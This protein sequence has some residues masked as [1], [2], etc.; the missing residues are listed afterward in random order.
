MAS[1]VDSRFDE[2][3]LRTTFDHGG[4]FSLATVPDSE[5]LSPEDLCLIVQRAQQL[6]AGSGVE[7]DR[8]QEALR[9]VTPPLD[10]EE[11][12]E[13][14]RRLEAEARQ[15]LEA[16]G[17]PPCYPPDVDVHSSQELPDSCRAIVKYWLS[18]SGGEDVPLCYQLRDWRK[19]RAYQRRKRVR[20]YK[21]SARGV[22][23]LRQKCGLDYNVRLAIDLEQQSP[24]DRW[25]EYQ[26]Y[27]LEHLEQLEKERD[28]FI[29][30]LAEFRS[31][32]NNMHDFP[33]NGCAEMDIERH[34]VLLDWIEKER[35][36]MSPRIAAT[37]L[38]SSTS[39]VG[40]KSPST[41]AHA[42][43][44]TTPKDSNVIPQKPAF[45]R[46]LR[47][48]N[49]EERNINEHSKDDSLLHHQLRPQRVTKR[50]HRARVPA[51]AG[52]LETITRY[53]RKSKLAERW[54]P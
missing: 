18:F 36:S 24:L 2:L 14:S 7:A 8:L 4:S 54:S 35:R 41:Q 10:E 53:G 46:H 23:R 39:T 12:R 32:N 13:I 5:G 28:Q 33:L 45:Q 52:P 42:T 17:C 27:H 40:Q 34:R 20:R 37:A 38:S 16:E 6:Q 30:E 43:T 9:D 22:Y 51:S 15:K 49:V 3:A 19:F 11:E 25:I 50:Q 31:A 47:P 26:A 1:P 29:K 21:N 48:R 44:R